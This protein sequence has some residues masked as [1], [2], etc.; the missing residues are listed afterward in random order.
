MPLELK[1]CCVKVVLSAQPPS[2]EAKP[3]E[4]TQTVV[5]AHRLI[6]LQLACALESAK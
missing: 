4:T 6:G 2:G 3:V 5:L 1:R